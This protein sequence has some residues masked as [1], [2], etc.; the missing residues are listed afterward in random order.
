MEMKTSK[1]KGNDIT[2]GNITDVEISEYQ[3][4]SEVRL[5]YLKFFKDLANYSYNFYSIHKSV[6]KEVREL[7]E[8]EFEFDVNYCSES[9][10]PENTIDDYT[11]ELVNER[12]DRINRISVDQKRNI[13][14]SISNYENLQFLSKGEI[15]HIVLDKLK[16]IINDGSK[17]RINTSVH[18]LTQGKDMSL[19][20]FR[21]DD[22]YANLDLESNYNDGFIDVHND[23]IEKIKGESVGLFLFHGDP[24][25]GKTTYLRHLIRTVNKRVIFIPPNI[26][27]SLSEPSMLNFL[28]DYP[29]SV[30]MIEDAEKLVESR[31]SGNGA[32]VSDLLNLSDGILGDCLRF[33]IICTFNTDVHNLDK[34]LLR[35]GRLLKKY[36]FGKLKTDKA[37][38][39]LN[40]LG[41][42]ETTEDMTLAQIYNDKLEEEEN[43]NRM[44]FMNRKN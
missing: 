19:S 1:I 14:L 11:G 38:K 25:T 24:G 27:T 9:F 37:N 35:E 28:M 30:L 18:M 40:K 34:A 44:G 8:K 17:N 13:V 23:V 3:D 15:D 6:R 10:T 31:N 41:K 5:I 12:E 2:I 4:S 42:E 22:K 20:D 32:A 39:I 16:N 43:N 33:Q 21:I 36:E 29:N 26:G 7:I